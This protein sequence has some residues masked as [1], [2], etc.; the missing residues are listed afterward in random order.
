M[1]K[2]HWWDQSYFWEVWSASGKQP[3]TCVTLQETW[4]CHHISCEGT[5]AVWAHNRPAF[6]PAHTATAGRVSITEAPKTFLKMAAPKAG[7][8]LGTR[9][10]RSENNTDVSWESKDHQGKVGQFS[11][12]C[13]FI[14]SQLHCQLHETLQGPLSPGHSPSI[15]DCLSSLSSWARVF[16]LRAKPWW[17]ASLFAMSSAA[18]FPVFLFPLGYPPAGNCMKS[19]KSWSVHFRSFQRSQSDLLGWGFPSSPQVYLSSFC[20][21]HAS[22]TQVGEPQ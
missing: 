22:M 20:S 21:K 3:T 6:L 11:R 1:L 13:P 2:C 8:S 15:W 7:F 17:S 9:R 4:W 12:Y 19:F 5:D 10:W 16:L 18:I 14:R